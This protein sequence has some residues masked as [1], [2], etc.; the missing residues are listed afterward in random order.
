MITI[1]LTGSEKTQN[2]NYD[3][4]F[5]IIEKETFFGR[6]QSETE[7]NTDKGYEIILKSVP[8]PAIEKIELIKNVE[9]KF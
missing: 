8:Q 2:K 3:T 7:K 1:I 4:I 6:V 9:V 5:D